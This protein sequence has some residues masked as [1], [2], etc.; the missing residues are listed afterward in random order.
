MRIGRVAID[1]TRAS[2]PTSTSTTTTASIMGSDNRF[3]FSC[4][5]ISIWAVAVVAVVVVV[6]VVYVVTAAAVVVVV[7]SNFL[8]KAGVNLHR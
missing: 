7:T 8:S 6:V 3:R 5:E 1:W 2:I 4:E